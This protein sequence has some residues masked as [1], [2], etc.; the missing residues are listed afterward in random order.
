ML[1]LFSVWVFCQSQAQVI[2]QKTSIF[3]SGFAESSGGNI[4]QFGVLGIPISGK[5]S[6][7]D[8]TMEIGFIIP[9]EDPIAS[10]DNEL[11]SK[12]IV[13]YPNPVVE[14]KLQ[15]GGFPSEKVKT[16]IYNA[17]GK[18]VMPLFKLPQENTIEVSHLESGLYFLYLYDGKYKAI[19]KF[20]KR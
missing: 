11:L 6:G 2:E 14:D 5:V 1:F 17:Q 20:Q 18:V 3:S 16:I 15:I 8:I 7:G 13:L 4:S 9:N 12:K 10:L 19:K